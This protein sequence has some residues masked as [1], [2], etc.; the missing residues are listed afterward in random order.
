MPQT[1]YRNN[2]KI[3][4]H[5]LIQRLQ[6]WLMID[7]LAE[8]VALSNLT[9]STILVWYLIHCYFNVMWTAISIEGSN[10][11]KQRSKK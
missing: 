4:S 10:I 7:K 11:A 9:N 3:P 2:D 6:K 8:Y 5:P 1:F